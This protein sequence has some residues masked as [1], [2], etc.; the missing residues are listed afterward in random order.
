MILI[1]A[2]AEAAG[3]RGGDV[4]V[5]VD[6]EDVTGLSQLELVTKV[7]GPAGSTVDLTMRRGDELVEF[8]I[9]RARI[10]IPAVEWEL[11]EGDL[12]YIKLRDFSVNA[13][14]QIDI[15]HTAHHVFALKPHR[16][17]FTAGIQRLQVSRTGGIQLSRVDEDLFEMVEKI[18][19]R[20]VNAEQQAEQ[21]R[22]ML[23]E[24]G[25]KNVTIR[26]IRQNGGDAGEQTFER[27]AGLFV[28][29][30]E[31]IRHETV[32]PANIVPNRRR[33]FLPL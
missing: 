28:V 9:Q 4:F 13:R 2:F 20:S 5:E 33:L 1:F 23:I 24:A 15:T 32:Y 22:E 11:L 19:M 8:S 25:K 30:H 31:S 10:T 17:S 14:E 26:H 7:R 16:I 29:G 21:I 12:G 18:I 3:L 27:K 6:G